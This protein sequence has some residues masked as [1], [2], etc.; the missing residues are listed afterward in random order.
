MS[1][2]TDINAAD[3]FLENF[4]RYLVTDCIAFTARINHETRTCTGELLNSTAVAVIVSMER[5]KMSLDVYD[6]VDW[7]WSLR[8][9]GNVCREWSVDSPE[10]I[11]YVCGELPGVPLLPLAVDPCLFGTLLRNWLHTSSSDS[12]LSAITGSTAAFS[13]LQTGADFLKAT[14]HFGPRDDNLDCDF[15]RRVVRLDENGFLREWSDLQCAVQLDGRCIR[16]LRERVYELTEVQEVDWSIWARPAGAR[17]DGARP[18]V[19][20][21]PRSGE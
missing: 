8:W 17:H 21:V 15:S 4:G 2:R 12:F 13:E 18:M 3:R 10:G 14:S 11:T 6:P 9:D 5:S 20:Y 7:N 1:G 16:H 19:S